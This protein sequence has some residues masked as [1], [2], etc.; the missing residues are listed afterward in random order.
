MEIKLD[1]GFL[2]I[3]TNTSS[4]QIKVISLIF[5]GTALLY[6]LYSDIDG[7]FRSTLLVA[8]SGLGGYEFGKQSSLKRKKA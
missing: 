2:K 3:L 1:L 5:L 8:I 4:N 7:A 6:C